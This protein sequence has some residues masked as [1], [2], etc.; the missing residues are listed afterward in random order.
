[1]NVAAREPDM[2]NGAAR[3]TFAAALSDDLNT[4]R[5]IEI[6]QSIS[7]DTLRDLGSVLGLT[8]EN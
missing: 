4:P 7:G 8:F 6:L 2:S 3:E 5:A 1:L